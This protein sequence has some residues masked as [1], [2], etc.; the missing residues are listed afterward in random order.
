MNNKINLSSNTKFALAIFGGFIFALVIIPVIAVMAFAPEQLGETVGIY[1]DNYEPENIEISVI[2]DEE[3]AHFYITVYRTVTSEFQKIEFERYIVGVVAAE[4]PAL[5]ERGALQ[6]QA[7]AARTYAMRILAHYEYILDTVMHQ[8]Y[9]D[10]E[11]LKAR[12]GD[13]FDLHLNTIKEA[14]NSTRGLVLK[15]DGEL[16]TPMFFAMS[17]GAT[18]NSEDFFATKRPYLRSV[19]STGYQHLENF[20]VNEKFTIADLQTAFID[21]QITPDNIIILS[22]SPGGNVSEIRIGNSIYTGREVREILGLRSAAFSVYIDLTNFMITFTTY[23]HGHGVGMSQHGANVM[24]RS[25]STFEEILKH[26]YQNV[27]IISYYFNK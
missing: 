20:A 14:V 1:N 15:Y 18:E 26:F 5:F 19:L 25:G 11:Q 6:A 13:D 12:W 16:I 9:L 3:E 27:E 2:W 24:A 7:V 17:S 10:D 23:G 21:Q 4:M 22:H 8:V